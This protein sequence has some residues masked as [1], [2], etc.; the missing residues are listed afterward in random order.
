MWICSQKKYGGAL[1]E[2]RKIKISKG[3]FIVE[4]SNSAD[5]AYLGSY[6]NEDQREDVMKDLRRWLNNP[7]SRI[8]KRVYIMPESVE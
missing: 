4:A 8:L 5:V 6:S 3:L 1:V 7:F 2:P